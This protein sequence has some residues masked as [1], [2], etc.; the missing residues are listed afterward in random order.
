MIDEPLVYRSKE[1]VLFDLAKA[2]PFSPESLEA[3]RNGRLSDQQFKRLAAHCAQPV[4]TALGLILAPF[5]FW[6]VI[7]AMR[8]QV[9]FLGGIPL[10]FHQLTHVDSLMEA[11]GKLGAAGMLGSIAACLLGAVY[12]L[13]RVS[14]QL[15]LD[16]LAGTVEKKEGRVTA[17]EEQRL[18]S[19]GRDPIEHYFFGTRDREY[20]VNAAACRALEDGAIYLLY[21]LPRSG[22]LVSLEPKIVKS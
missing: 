3:N 12:M 16:L 22:E 6:A 17:R 4:L 9:P 7:V 15:H 8:E 2:F 11:R 20:P 5:A 13:S 18:R 19:S 1:Q 21:V 10:L 14:L